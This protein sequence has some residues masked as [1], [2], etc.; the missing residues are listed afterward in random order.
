M[1]E[2]M[3][4]LMV[5]PLVTWWQR[6]KGLLGTDR[7]AGVVALMNCRSIHTFWMRYNLDVA[8]VS[9][10]GEVLNSLRNVPPFKVLSCREASFVLER[11]ARDEPWPQTGCLMHVGGVLL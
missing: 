1:D 7:S 10:D 9:S 6:L 11:P 8:F 2:N 5:R 4:C 3:G